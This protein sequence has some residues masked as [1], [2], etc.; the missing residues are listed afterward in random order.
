MFY[1]DMLGHHRQV[2]RTPTASQ[3]KGLHQKRQE[4][5][6]SSIGHFS[7]SQ[8]FR[9]SS[10][11]A[12]VLPTVLC[13]ILAIVVASF[14]ISIIPTGRCTQLN[15][16]WGLVPEPEEEWLCLCWVEGREL[17]STFVLLVFLGVRETKEG[18]YG[19]CVGHA[20]NIP[21]WKEVRVR[22][23]RP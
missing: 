7:L 9:T 12:P 13:W 17:F 11:K 21:K 3:G 18:G 1:T 15:I 2:L 22:F 10:L 6:F 14:T 19:R 8:W 5:T 4:L 20:F 23:E 16:D